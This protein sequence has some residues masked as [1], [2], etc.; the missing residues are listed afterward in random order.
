MGHIEIGIL[1]ESVRLTRELDGGAQSHLKECE[2]CRKRLHW[3]RTAA[4][5]GPQELEFEPPKELLD[6]VLRIGKAPDYL[7]KIRSFIT[8]SWTFDSLKDLAPAGVRRT[9]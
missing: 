2:E 1:F 9:E 6:K 7:K 8:A 4:A 3:M 5:L